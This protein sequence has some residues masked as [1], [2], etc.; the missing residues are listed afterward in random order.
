[1]QILKNKIG[2]PGLINYI[3]GGFG[4]AFLLFFVLPV[5]FDPG[6]K[7]LFP[8]T[9]MTADIIGNDL[10]TIVSY[11]GAYFRDGVS[12]YAGQYYFYPPFTV[13]LFAPFSFLP[14]VGA[15]FLFSLITFFSYILYLAF[16][17]S[18]FSGKKISG[19]V[20]V[21][22]LITGLLS[23]GFQ[24]EIE[25]GQF[26]VIA[27]VLCV[28]AIYIFHYKPKWRLLSY[29][30]FVISVQLKIYPAI[31]VL[32]LVDDWHAWKQNLIRFAS[33]SAVSF[34][35]LLI[36]GKGLFSEFLYNVIFYVE[37][38]V[39]WTGNHSISSFVSLVT[40][41]SVEKL[42]MTELSWTA[43][44]APAARIALL[45]AYLTVLFFS[46][47]DI[48]IKNA[49][50]FSRTL[51]FVCVIG[52]QIIPA[53]SHDYKLALTSLPVLLM[54]DEFENR[55]NINAD[56]VS[57]VLMFF[58]SFFYSAL[59]FSYTNKPVFLSNNFP[60]LFLLLLTVFALH[61]RLEKNNI[62]PRM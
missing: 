20:F 27:V 21:F 44:F 1:M 46:V 59:L 22:F 35:F 19:S 52:S 25:R 17:P 18:K 55:W 30:L 10:L 29:L 45:L 43:A 8:G 14:H 5:F 12:P 37:N 26:N 23:Y 38:P 42:G 9:F 28:S 36:L 48:Y 33:L 3:F 49:K 58:S 61:K 50:G 7:M 15:F 40:Q 32:L 57:R 60:V 13:L 34:L 51:F 47:R 41:K 11:S 6:H 4:F 2:N 24:F 56:A 39:S 53:I 16:F 54:F 31:F 62:Q